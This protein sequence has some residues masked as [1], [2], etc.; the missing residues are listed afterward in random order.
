MYNICMGS[1]GHASQ[2]G[3]TSSFRLRAGHLGLVEPLKGLDLAHSAHCKCN[4][5]EWGCSSVGRTSDR[6][7][8]DAGS[9]PRCRKGFFSQSQLSAQTLLRV[10]VH[11]RLQSHARTSVRTLKIL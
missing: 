2:E 3:P 6:H 5:E 4:S 7:V 1:V 9:I 8:A 11:P 10:S